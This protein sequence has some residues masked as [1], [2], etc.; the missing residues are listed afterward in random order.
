METLLMT[1]LDAAEP[2]KDG[3]KALPGQYNF[4]DGRS[5]AGALR[6]G[7]VPHTF[8][9]LTAGEQ[10]DPQTGRPKRVLVRILFEA[11][12]LLHADFMTDDEPMLITPSNGSGKIVGLR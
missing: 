1:L 3:V 8:E 6:A 4:R 9:I 2:T 7:P 11:S 5:I 10:P 12:A